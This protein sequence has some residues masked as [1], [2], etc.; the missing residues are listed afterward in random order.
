MTRELYTDFARIRVDHPEFNEHALVG[1]KSPHFVGPLDDGDTV[2]IE[3]V[4]VSKRN[5][6]GLVPEAIGVDMED[7][8]SSPVLIHES[9]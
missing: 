1:E 3:I 6:F 2:R 7:G 9:E 4:L 5:H 8:D